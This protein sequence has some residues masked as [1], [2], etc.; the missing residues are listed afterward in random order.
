[1]NTLARAPGGQMRGAATKALSDIVEERQQ[2]LY[3]PF[4]AAPLRAAAHRAAGRSSRWFCCSLLTYRPG[5]ARRSRLAG[6]RLQQ[7][8]HIISSQTLR[9]FS[10]NSWNSWLDS[11]FM[12]SPQRKQTRPVRAIV[13]FLRLSVCVLFLC[14]CPCAQASSVAE[15]ARAVQQLVER[16][17]L[18]GARSQLARALKQY[19][20]EPDLH[21]LLGVVEAQ[22]GNYQSAESSFLRSIQLAPGAPGAYL[23]LGRLYQENSSRDSQALPKAVET[24]R[25]LLKHHPAD[26]EG[27]YQCAL[28]LQQQGNFRASLDNL[29]RLPAADQQRTQALAVLCADYAALGDFPEAT[30]A[31]SRLLA[32]QELSE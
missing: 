5:I 6:G 25:K 19:P 15:I 9:L 11:Q 32:N 29:A 13:T 10:C 12:Q 22:T 27:N 30:E 14:L 3:A 26:V 2:S 28:L 1:M 4:A 23:N 7:S 31:A 18:A 16:G 17:D 21:N 20:A 24:Y 8:V